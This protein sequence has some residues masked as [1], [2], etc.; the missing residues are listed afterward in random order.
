VTD[1][2]PGAGGVMASTRISV[3]TITLNSAATI[4][5]TL[6]SV[7][8]QSYPYVEHL[9]ID[10]NSSD[11]TLSIVQAQGRTGIRVL[12]EPDGGIYQA[13]N[14]GLRLAQGELVGF[15]NADDVYQDAQVLADVARVAQDGRVDAIYGD[16]VYVSQTNPAWVIRHWHSGRWTPGRLRFGWMPPHPTVYVRKALIDS[17]G[18]FDERLRIAADYDFMLRLLNC[19]RIHVAYLERVMVRMR[20]GGASNRSLAM[21]WQKSREDLIALKRNNIG[22]WFT[23][24]CKNVRKLPQFVQGMLWS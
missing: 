17:L 19:S 24:L 6:Q 15:L 2:D 8:S 22:G 16:L 18:G 20:T 11:D 5:D 4:A 7:A 3:V 9:V 23:L 14:K 13:M 21:M 10:G 1:I 12:S